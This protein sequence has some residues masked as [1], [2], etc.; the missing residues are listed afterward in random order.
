LSP[1]IDST[2]IAPGTL[3]DKRSAASLNDADATLTAAN[4]ITNGILVI[5]PTADRDLTLPTAA[6]IVALATGYISGSTYD[7]NI[8]N[9]GHS[10][11]TLIAG[12]G[13]IIVGDPIIWGSQY[14]GEF[15]AG[16]KLIINSAT[17][18][19]IYRIS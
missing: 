12:T 19:T 15:P 8:I 16:F 14:S 10:D 17:A 9:L 2:E 7:F 6:E 11:L 1:L 5:T 4:L 3:V 13:V 18:V